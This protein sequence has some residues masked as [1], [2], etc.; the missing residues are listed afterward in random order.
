ML[1]TTKAK[2]M[3]GSLVAT[4]S[5]ISETTPS[6][7]HCLHHGVPSSMQTTCE[8]AGL[9]AA[10]PMLLFSH[11]LVPHVLQQIPLALA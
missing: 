11:H 7:A 1:S 4:L 9:C 6:A 3:C 10:A 8:F 2:P 5:G